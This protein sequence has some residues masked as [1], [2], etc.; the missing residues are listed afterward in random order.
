MRL[1]LIGLLSVAHASDW[2]KACRSR[3][4]DARREATRLDARFGKGKVEIKKI[5]KG[6]MVSYFLDL[7]PKLRS[8][9]GGRYFLL[10]V[11]DD[12]DQ[13]GG[14]WKAEHNFPDQGP[15]ARERRALNGRAAQVEAKLSF[16]S[17]EDTL[18]RD[19]WLL[20]RRAADDCLAH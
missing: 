3:L 18:T 2:P 19:L 13:A 17:E 16:P 1:W 20:W 6:I 14:P 15:R 4:L 9:F 12:P 10:T 7:D 8:R 11:V 5:P